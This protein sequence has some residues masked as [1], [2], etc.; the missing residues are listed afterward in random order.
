VAETA[1]ESIRG[2]AAAQALEVTDRLSEISFAIRP[3]TRRKKFPTP[4]APTAQAELF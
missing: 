2:Q 4:A 3:P 1:V